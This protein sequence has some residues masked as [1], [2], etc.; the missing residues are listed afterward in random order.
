MKGKRKKEDE[1]MQ[2]PNLMKKERKKRWSKV[3]A[4]SDSGSLH[5]V[6]FIEMPL[7]YE[8]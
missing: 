8:L 6:L 4:E 1:E 3:A 5:V 7:S 2:A